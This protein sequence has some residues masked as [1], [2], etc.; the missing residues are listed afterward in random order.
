MELVREHAALDPL[1]RELT[2][3]GAYVGAKLLDRLLRGRTPQ[4]QRQADN[5]NA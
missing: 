5:R 2:A 1:D 4:Q 3:A